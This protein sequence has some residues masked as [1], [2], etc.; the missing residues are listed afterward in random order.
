MRISLL[1]VQFHEGNNLF[2]PLGLLYV[3][4]ALRDAGHRVHVLDGDPQFETDLVD[5]VVAFRPELIGVSFLTMTWTRAQALVAALRRRLPGVPIMAG[6]PHAT[7]ES[8]STLHDLPAD[9]VVRGEGETTAVE[10]A[11]RLAS[12]QSL[13]GILGTVTG[14]G[15]APDRPPRE[16]LD[17]LPLPAR[18]LLDFERYLSAPGLIRGRA[19]ARHAS[20]MAG[21]GCRYRCTF[22]ASHLQ[23]GRDLRMRSIDDVLSEL[24]HLVETW[25]I[26][27]VY[28]VDDIFTGDKPWVRAF[29]AALQARPYTL[30]WGCQSRVESVDEEL[31]R[32]MKRA[33]CVQVDFGV[34]SGSKQVLR[35]MKKGTTWRRV[36][37]AFDLAHAVGLR[38]GA[39]FILGSPGEARDDLEDTLALAARIDSDW[40][41]F[42]FSTPYPGTELWSQLKEAGTVATLP[43]YG[44]EWNNRQNKAPFRLSELPPEH[45]SECRKRA[46]NRH[47]R[48]NYL[49]ARNL[50]FAL[51]LARRAATR[52]SLVTDALRLLAEGGRIDDAV[53]AW[54]AAD[55]AAV[56]AWR[57]APGHFGQSQPS[58]W[59]PQPSSSSVSSS[60]ATSLPTSVSAW[61][62]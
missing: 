3:A 43:A 27:G 23:L 52:P 62:R 38:T 16:D 32:C 33:G 14:A 9:I 41:V 26:R 39:S 42:F 46:Q 45:L 19:S 4:G 25:R 31:L 2:P 49:S 1:H 54:F 59:T 56:T 6:G 55:R 40:T 8:A 57:P 24:D 11:G 20:V 30:E 13:D 58:R 47:F 61:T 12:G 7:A 34:E 48:R 28:F 50:G 53:E 22:C 29:C 21:R 36:V 5:R 15:R 60:S 18:D 35:A 10:I 37:E 44:V 51:R 17:T